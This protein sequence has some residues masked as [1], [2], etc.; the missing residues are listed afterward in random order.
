MVSGKRTGLNKDGFFN[1]LVKE[2]DSG[3]EYIFIKKDEKKKDEMITP[4]SCP[5]IDLQL[6]KNDLNIL[7]PQIQKVRN[8]NR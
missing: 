1:H 5:K 4:L 7:N 6:I 8:L 2:I 3:A